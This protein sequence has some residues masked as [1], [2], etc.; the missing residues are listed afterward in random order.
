MKE[1]KLIPFTKSV[2]KGKEVT[3]RTDRVNIK[4]KVNL[5]KPDEKEIRKKSE[6]ICKNRFHE[7][8]G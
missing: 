5:K 3:H 6:E 1:K 7:F 2:W 8:Y 4:L